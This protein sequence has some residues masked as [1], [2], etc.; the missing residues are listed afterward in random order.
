LGLRTGEH[1]VHHVSE[2]IDCARV[3]GRHVVVRV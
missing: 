1:A 3:K 2:R